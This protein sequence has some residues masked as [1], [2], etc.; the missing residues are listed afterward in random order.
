MNINREA[1]NTRRMREHQLSKRPESTVAHEEVDLGVATSVIDYTTSTALNARPDI[2]NVRDVTQG[3]GKALVSDAD[4]Q[5]I[6]KIMFKDPCTVTA[7]IVRADSPPDQEGGSSE[8]ISGPKNIK[9]Y[10]N[11]EDLDFWE[12]QDIPAAQSTQ[13]DAGEAKVVLKGN[14]FQRVNSIQIF[15]ADN[16]GDTPLTY[17]NQLSLRG[18]VCPPYTHQHML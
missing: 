15:A 18:F 11:R 12:V 1:A 13:I 8:P 2:G 4:E 5:L 9:F 17:I 3:T 7:V 10:S 6:L 16:Q 14:K